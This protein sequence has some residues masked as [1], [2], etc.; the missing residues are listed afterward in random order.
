MSRV[1][2]GGEV[3]AVRYKP[4]VRCLRLASFLA[5]RQRLPA[6]TVMAQELGVCERTIRRYL[7]SLEEARWPL[8]LKA[9]EGE[10]GDFAEDATPAAFIGRTDH[11]RSIGR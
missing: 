8:P 11:G 9:S 6:F 10:L 2:E 3:T 5:G 4:L 7:A 1:P